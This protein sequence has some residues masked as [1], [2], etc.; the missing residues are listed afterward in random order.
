MAIYTSFWFYYTQ[1]YPV[2]DH[3]ITHFH[4]FSDPNPTQNP[5]WLF[6]ASATSLTNFSHDDWMSAK[7][8]PYK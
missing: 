1:L 8:E 5:T 7:M 4:G 2:I 3:N 6:S